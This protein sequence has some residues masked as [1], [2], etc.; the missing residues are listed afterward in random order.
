[1]RFSSLNP[2]TIISSRP[3]ATRAGAPPADEIV[4]L[5]FRPAT[6]E[7]FGLGDASHLYVISPPGGGASQ[8]GSNG[9]FSL[10]GQIFGFD[11]NPVTDQIRVT[12]HIEENFRINP[13]DG[14]LAGTD[15]NIN[16]APGDPN[17]AFNRD[18]V[19]A[20]HTN[21]FFGAT[22]TTL[23]DIDTARNVLVRQGGL[24]VPPGTPP[25]DSGQIFTIETL[26]INPTTPN[27]GFDIY[28]LL[29]GTNFA[30]AALS[31][32]GTTSDLYRINLTTGAANQTGTG[33]IGG[34]AT[35]L[36]VRALAA[37]PMGA[38]EFSAPTYSVSESGPVA[39]ITV[40]RVRGREGIVTVLLS[41]SD[42]TATVGDLDYTDSDQVL[43]FGPIVTSRTVTIALGNDATSEPDETVNLTLSNPTGGAALAAQTTAVL[44][45]LN[46]DGAPT[47]TPTP[48]PTATPVTTLANIST[49]LR[50]ETGDNVLIGGFIV[51][52][53]QPK[54]VI[55]RAIGTS[56]PLADKLADP[57][58]EL[59]GPNGLI[60]AND[61]WADSPNMQAIIDSTIPPT[62]NLESAIVQT[63]PANNAGYT[64]IVRGVNEGTGIALV[65]A[66]D[67]DIPANSKLANISTRGFVQ[68]GDN[69]LIAGTIVVGQAPQ[70]VLIRA[71]GPSLPIG[72]K[73]ENPTLELRDSNGTLLQASDNWVDSADKQAI[74]DTTIPPTNDLE[75]AIVATLPANNASYTAILRGVGDTTGI[76]V[77]EVYALP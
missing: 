69:V 6:G 15:P 11:F 50:V 27:T 72:G 14:T 3:I 39:S 56:L 21:N 36:L 65:E 41:T 61:N 32:D 74:M 10:S 66:Y 5:D 37:A 29:D 23:Y 24:N 71:I 68:T 1:V 28:T 17:A 77:V 63:L 26:G 22:T 52:G 20:A 33:P 2:A 25:P 47:P 18:V 31:T 30:F 9:Q 16:S 70:E 60:E 62:S 51:T 53:T 64:A 48:T 67:L 8:R 42:G 12:S 13:N 4:G 46:N 58:M 34:A 7:L 19:G 55:V 43:I 57:T 75:S 49:R 38:F 73:L 44:T 59:H 35:P 54:K 40:N 76:A 45:I